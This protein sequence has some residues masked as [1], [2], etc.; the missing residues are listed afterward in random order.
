MDTQLSF[1]QNSPTKTN[2][3]NAKKI[4][5]L[6]YFQ[7]YI[8][9]EEEKVF[10]KEINNSP[11][12]TDIKRWTQHY[13]FQYDYRARK[14][15]YSMKIGEL[16]EWSSVLAQRLVDDNIFASLPDQL[17]IN[18]YEAGQGIAPH[19]D[20]EPCFEDTIVSI[21]LNTPTLIEFQKDKVKIP[22]LLEPRSLIVMKGESRY[23]WKHGIPKRKTDKF[24]DTIYK[25]GRRISLTFRK[26]F[27][28]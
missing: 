14:I 1:F 4:S 16:P 26:V 22:F 12:Q 24:N 21:S 6:S 3:E 27:I 28:V 11:W 18:N 23:F 15:D 19:T 2:Q 5:G 20:C 9:E 13:G 8:S 17:L 7:N 10:F 25:R